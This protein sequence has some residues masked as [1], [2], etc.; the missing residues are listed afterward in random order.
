MTSGP[1]SVYIEHGRAISLASWHTRVE[2]P[3]PPTIPTSLF[4][5]FSSG[6]LAGTLFCNHPQAPVSPPVSYQAAVNQRTDTLYRLSTALRRISLAPLCSVRMGLQKRGT[7]TLS[8][9]GTPA[10]WM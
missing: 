7:V 5:Q 3:P 6:N 4:S 8:R 10:P 1:D 9:L 2:R